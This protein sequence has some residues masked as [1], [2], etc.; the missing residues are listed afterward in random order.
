MKARTKPRLFGLWLF[1]LLF[2]FRI[3][4][5]PLSMSAYFSSMPPFEAWYSGA[6]SYPVLL[7][8]QGLILFLMLHV[9]VRW[10]RGIAF[11]NLRT[12]KL[13]LGLGA[14]YMA[15]M[16]ARLILGLTLMVGHS[17]FDRPLPTAFHLVL[18]SY[19]LVLSSLHLRPSRT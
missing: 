15:T 7:V 17:W 9:N 11:P 2:A 6:L 1:T 12:G 19:V 16:L 3:I 13:L 8:W 5:Q 4:A 18:A 14:L 10:S